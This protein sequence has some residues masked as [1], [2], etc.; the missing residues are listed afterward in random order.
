MPVVDAVFMVLIVQQRA[1]RCQELYLLRNVQL[2]GKTNVPRFSQLRAMLYLPS[3]GP[4][5]DGMYPARTYG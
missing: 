1:T 2:T 3:W 4:P 5:R